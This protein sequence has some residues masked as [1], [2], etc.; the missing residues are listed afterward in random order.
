MPGGEKMATS[1]GLVA[2]QY[3]PFARPWIIQPCLAIDPGH[4]NN[5]LLLALKDRNRRARYKAV[6]SIMRGR[7][8]EAVNFVL[9]VLKDPDASVRLAATNCLIQFNSPRN[10]DHLLRVLHDPYPA[11]RANAVGALKKFPKQKYRREVQKLVFDQ[12]ASVRLAALDTLLELHCAEE[13]VFQLLDLALDKHQPQNARALAFENIRRAEHLPVSL[14]KE[15]E[16]AGRA[17]DGIDLHLEIVKVL[18]AYPPG[19][20]MQ[21]A[22]VQLLHH[23]SYDVHRS[24]ILALG[25]KGDRGAIYYLSILVREGKKSGQLMNEY[26]ARMAEIAIEKINRRHPQVD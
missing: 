1:I 23:V 12:N 26:D 6:Q 17:E 16:Q 22:L 7:D 5:I 8:R 2:F 10:A 21:V 24:A 20:E 4:R 18:A 19:H 15:L 13:F 11:I 14:I 9:M 25:E 3:L